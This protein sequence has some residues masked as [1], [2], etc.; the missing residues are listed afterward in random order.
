MA[1]K[2]T[3]YMRF[4]G[5]DDHGVVMPK[6]PVTPRYSGRVRSKAT[7]FKSLADAEAALERA[8]KRFECDIQGIV[9]KDGKAVLHV[10]L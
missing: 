2:F 8:A 3:A 5:E 1:S 7:H 4:L 6:T 9:Y 10:A